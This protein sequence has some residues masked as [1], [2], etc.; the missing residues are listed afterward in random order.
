M[1]VA[2]VVAK[3]TGKAAV[4]VGK[5]TISLTATAAKAAFNAAKEQSQKQKDGKENST[6]LSRFNSAVDSAKKK[7]EAG[8]KAAD[9]I[10]E[11]S[12]A[13]EAVE[14]PLTIGE[15]DPLLELEVADALKS[16]EDALTSAKKEKNN[17]KTT[18]TTLQ[19]NLA[20]EKARVAAAKARKDAEDL[21]L[22]LEKRK[23]L[24]FKP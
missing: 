11:S 21:E 4:V 20:L 2:G 24:F 8:V 18:Q 1:D 3:T 14:T 17:P 22:M 10:S 15:I 7:K 13:L 12:V 16:A 6:L 9:A 5:G 23:E 19:I